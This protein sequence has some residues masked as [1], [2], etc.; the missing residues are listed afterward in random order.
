ME[1]S[2]YLSGFVE[3]GQLTNN[4]MSG[5]YQALSTPAN[6][7][8]DTNDEMSVVQEHIETLF[9][10]KLKKLPTE[11]LENNTILVNKLLF[12]L[13]K[14]CESKNYHRIG[15]IYIG[16]CDYFDLDFIKVYTNLHEKIQERIQMT[17]KSLIGRDR[18]AKLKE[19][20]DLQKTGG[21]KTTTLFSLIKK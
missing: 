17:L 7:D 16:F 8:I 6:T 21:V 5:V 15:F 12:E 10:E 2:E 11:T 9:N 4:E 14:Y 1:D 13:I 19:K 20:S 18:F 3:D